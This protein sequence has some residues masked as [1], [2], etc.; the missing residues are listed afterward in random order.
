MQILKYLEQE[1]ALMD[2]DIQHSST[3]DPIALSAHPKPGP[4]II[5]TNCKRSGH[6]VTYCISPG[7]GMAGKTIEDSKQA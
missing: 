7:G 2:S 4:A 1:Q 6:L 5:C 3:Q